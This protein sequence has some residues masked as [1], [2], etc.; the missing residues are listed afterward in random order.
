MPKTKN[1]VPVWISH[2]GSW[3]SRH[4][5]SLLLEFKWVTRTTKQTVRCHI[6][7][8]L[9]ATDTAVTFA[10]TGILA[11]RF[12]YVFD[13]SSSCLIL[14]VIIIW[15]CTSGVAAFDR[16]DITL[17][18]RC[19]LSQSKV[20]SSRTTSYYVKMVILN[21]RRRLAT[22]SQSHLRPN[23]P[24]TV[25]A[26]YDAILCIYCKIDTKNICFDGDSWSLDD[27]SL[28]PS[29]SRCSHHVMS[30]QVVCVLL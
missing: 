4:M 9:A 29:S 22:P 24:A 12:Y 27:L 30:H 3:S 19:R 14:F 6:F 26:L 2:T 17:A 10:A 13:C 20:D 5:A 7:W 18:A 11:D 23:L 8:R 28:L 16:Y 25:I 21:S 1:K 15:L